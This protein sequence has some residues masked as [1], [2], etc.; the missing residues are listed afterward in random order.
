MP[1]NSSTSDDSSDD[2]EQLALL[3]EATDQ[4]LIN[5]HMFKNVGKEKQTDSAPTSLI[6]SFVL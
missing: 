4:S 6:S 3:R 5:D 1:S 2:D